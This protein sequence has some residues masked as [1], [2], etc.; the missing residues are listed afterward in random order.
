MGSVRAT[1]GAPIAH[2][3]I[4]LGHALDIDE[5]SMDCSNHGALG[6][7]KGV[8]HISIYNTII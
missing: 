5:R 4:I 8:L 2:L 6:K 3:S 7:T 1:F